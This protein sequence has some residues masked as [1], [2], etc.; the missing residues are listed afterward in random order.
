MIGTLRQRLFA[1]LFALVVVEQMLALFDAVGVRFADPYVMV[2]L[3]N[4][5]APVIGS[6]FWRWA[7]RS[8][9]S[10][11]RTVWIAPVTWVVWAGSYYL[12][13]A[14]TAKFPMAMPVTG[15]TAIESSLPLVPAAVLVYMGVHPMSALPF[16]GLRNA[17]DVTRHALGHL[18]IVA[19]SIVCWAALPIEFPRAELPPHQGSL[20]LWVLASMRQNDPALNC[21]PSTHCSMAVYAAI[22]LQ[23]VNASLGRW[24]AITAAAISIST[25]LT[26]Q[27]YL[28]DVLSGVA[29]GYVVGRRIHG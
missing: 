22:G 4:S 21:L 11:P 18:V 23:R 17:L 28:V 15:L 12:V 29:L 19:I 8:D 5:L 14:A 2:L 1:G 10:A 24:A 27:H 9:D 16:L 6:L 20:G 7:P 3:G 26:R 25:L 13:A